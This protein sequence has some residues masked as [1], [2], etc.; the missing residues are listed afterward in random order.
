MCDSLSPF[1]PVLLVF[2]SGG[3]SG[4]L[5]VKLLPAGLICH[6]PPSISCGSCGTVLLSVFHVLYGG[7]IFNNETQ[8][9]AERDLQC[10]STEI[11]CGPGSAGEGKS[12]S[13]LV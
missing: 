12:T 9:E 4:I 3:I 5:F 7:L 11:L 10:R 6:S 8:K 2:H 1:L 13:S